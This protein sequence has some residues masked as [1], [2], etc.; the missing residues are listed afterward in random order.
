MSTATSGRAREH[1]TRDRLAESATWLK[2]ERIDG[3]ALALVNDT[4]HDRFWSKVKPAAALDCWEWTGSSTARGYGKFFVCKA[5]GRRTV[6]IAAHRWSFLMLRGGIGDLLLDHLCRNRLCV[7]PWH[8]EPVTNAVNVS[9]G[10]SWNGSK[11]HCKRGH[12]FTPENTGRQNGGY[13]YCV[14]CKRVSDAKRCAA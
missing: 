14:T 10:V 5:E 13:R 9:R 3:L 8:L 7:N 6:L 4:T 12:E 11:T 1:R 2:V